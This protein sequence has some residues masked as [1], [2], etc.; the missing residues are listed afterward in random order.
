M[1]GGLGAEMLTCQVAT[2]HPKRTFSIDE[3]EVVVLCPFLYYSLL[4][5]PRS[6]FSIPEPL[7]VTMASVLLCFF[8]LRV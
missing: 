2:S 7:V 1:R 3:A 8:T 4:V 6:L 5:G